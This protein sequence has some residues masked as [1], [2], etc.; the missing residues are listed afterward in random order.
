MG[1][2][3]LQKHL[4]SAL[5]FPANY[6][7]AARSCLDQL[8]TS[9]EE[10]VSGINTERDHPAGWWARAFTRQCQDALHELTFLSPSTAP[11]IDEIPTLRE[12]AVLGNQHAIERLSAIEKACTAIQ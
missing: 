7:Y 6:A 12:L 10:V 4:E 5:K 8:T 2:T 9:A 11:G 1:L 3:Q